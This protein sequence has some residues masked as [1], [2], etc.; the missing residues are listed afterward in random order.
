M[1]LECKQKSGKDRKVRKLANF[2]IAMV[3]VK[4]QVYISVHTYKIIRVEYNFS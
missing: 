3:F 1:V 2:F 4:G